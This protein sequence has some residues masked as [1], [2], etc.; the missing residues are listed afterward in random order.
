[1][2]TITYDNFLSGTPV[3]QSA[4]TIYAGPASGIAKPAFRALTTADL[5][6]APGFSVHKNGTGQS[7]AANT[8]VKVTWPT[9]SYDIGG[10]FASSRFTVVSAGGYL[11]TINLLWYE[12]IAVGTGLLILLYKN[13]AAYRVT[14][15]IVTAIG[16]Y[17]YTDLPMTVLDRAVAG[18]Y[19][20]VYVYQTDSVARTILGD[21]TNTIWSAQWLG[22]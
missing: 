21:A 18:D 4:N 3:E 19:Y 1:M 20:E 10:Q 17:V 2:T 12:G 22:N 11:F 5:P 14:R 8:A 13:G 6:S 15:T 9:E 7:I 16:S